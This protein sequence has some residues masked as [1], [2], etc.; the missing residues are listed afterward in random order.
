MGSLIKYVWKS[1]YSIS[2]LQNSYQRRQ[3]V[4]SK[5]TYL[6]LI[7]LAFSPF[8]WRA[9]LKIWKSMIGSVLSIIIWG[10]PTWQIVLVTF[11]EQ[12]QVNFWSLEQWKTFSSSSSP[13][14]Y[15]SLPYVSY[16]SL[17]SLFFNF[18]LPSSSVSF[19]S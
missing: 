9:V 19:Y 12:N 10:K 15:V 11:F 2:L 14:V 8:I 1:L 18:P 17:N 7:K 4:L 16:P 3:E 5:E 6:P 13:I